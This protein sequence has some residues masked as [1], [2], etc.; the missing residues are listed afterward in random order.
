VTLRPFGSPPEPQGFYPHERVHVNALTR[1]ESVGY[2]RGGEG[3]AS[4]PEGMNVTDVETG[5]VTVEELIERTEALLPAIAGRALEAERARRI[6]EESLREIEA[7][8]LNR[9]LHPARWGGFG[10]DYDAFFEVSWRL[11]SACGSTGWVFNVASVHNWQLGLAS[12]QA[13][14][15]F[16]A[17][18]DVWSCSGFNPS[19]AKAEAVEG[20]WTVS[21]RWAW[22][23][24]SWH[25]DWCLLAA[26]VPQFPFPILLM[27][28]REDVR[29]EDVW[30]TS[31]LRGTGSNDVVIDEPVFVPEHRWVPMVGYFPDGVAEHG[32]GTYGVPIPSLIPWTLVTPLIGMAQGALNAYEDKTRTR[33]TAITHQAV[34]HSVGAQMRI[35]EAAAAIDSARALARQDIAE[36]KER[37]ARLD[38]F[39]DEDRVRFRRDHAYAASLAYDA[40]MHLARASGASSIMETHP[41][42]RCM[43]D[44]HAAAMHM[45]SSWDDQAESYGRV[46]LGLEPNGQFW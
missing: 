43:R 39:T 12:E 41:M 25:A 4:H 15:E 16:F 35:A 3:S 18:G 42:Q 22:S 40:V 27:I 28:P 20:G 31:G 9:I 29:I 23:S 7:A 45:V 37:G 14:E 21:G 36:L 34:A 8:G 33:Q 30:F 6:P 2:I 44:A 32:R 1:I 11:A 13:Q 5:V 38:T 19:G 26:M 24:G 10:L 46:R 17:G